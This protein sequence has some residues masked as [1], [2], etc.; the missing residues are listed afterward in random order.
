LRDL[1]AH[2]GLV[3]VRQAA[4][5]RPGRHEDAG[6]VA[7]VQRADQQAGHDLVADA[8][9]QR[10]SNTSCESAIGRAMAMVSRENRLSS[11]PAGPA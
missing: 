1:L 2:L 6:Q 8:Q 11:M 3:A 9:Q 7:E 4:A 5:H 10:A